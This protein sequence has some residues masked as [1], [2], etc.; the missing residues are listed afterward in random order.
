[1]FNLK[2]ITWFLLLSTIAFGQLSNANKTLIHTQTGKTV[3]KGQLT[4]SNDMNFYSNVAE[5]IGQ[6]EPANFSETN[7]WLVAGNTNL[8]Y[9]ITDVLDVSLGLRL[10]QDTHRR[11]EYNLPDD[12]FLTLRAGSFAFGRNHFYQGFLTSFRFPT[13]EVHNY[14]FAE[15]ASGAFEYGLMYA[16][17]YYDDP[18]LPHRAYSLHFN[19]GW[20]NHN[21]AGRTFKFRNGSEFESGVSSNDI[22]MALA[23]VFP[24]ALFDFRLELSGILYA[25]RPESFVYSAEEWAYFTPSVRFKPWKSLSFDLAADLLLSPSDRQWTTA[26]IPDISTNLDLPTSYPNW[27]IHMG[28]NVSLNVL[29]QNFG[30]GS[31]YAREEAKEK[32]ELFETILEEQEKAETVQG[33]LE[34]LR[35][36]RKEAEK[37]IEELE[38]L[39]N[40]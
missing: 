33:Q 1:M 4:F 26:D 5:F 14:P 31:N 38:K 24:T 12:I 32:I 6:S 23:A 21:E 22:R 18:Y 39:I 20:W 15:Y 10:Y 8:T 29:K 2:I 3:D 36:V 9:G 25:Q 34:N 35:R 16:V 13:G 27:K 7:Y 40:E 11:N 17:S 30:V 37:E 19:I 28:A